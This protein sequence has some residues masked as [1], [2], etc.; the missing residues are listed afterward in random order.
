MKWISEARVGGDVVFRIGRDGAVLVAEWP[1]S[2]TLR[3]EP[4]RTPELLVHPE[5]EPAFVDKLRNG[6][7]R[8]LLRHLE[9]KI[10]MH[11]ATIAWGAEALCLLGDSGQGKSTLSAALCLHHGAT[12]L[13]DDVAH[14]EREGDAVWVTPAHEDHSLTAEACVALGV[15]VR[16]DARREKMPAPAARRTEPGRLRAFVVLA[17]GGDGPAL[18]R[19]SGF[20]ALGPVVSGMAR[21]VL[22]DA[23]VTARDLA[24]A[25]EL[26]RAVPVYQLSR[27]RD[28]SRLAEC[29]DA[30]RS[31]L[32]EGEPDGHR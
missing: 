20:R 13:G 29:T 26:A 25:A 31:L 9:G 11:G 32:G 3:V 22:D 7:V 16:A 4:G 10:T 23:A 12:L 21:F 5:S 30:L 2:L 1:D 18:T 27:P 14:L 8:A 19:L 6:P 28:L 15:P 24:A 17:F